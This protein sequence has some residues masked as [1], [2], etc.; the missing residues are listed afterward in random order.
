MKI[1]RKN[2]YFFHKNISYEDYP[3]KRLSNR[4]I[5]NF[6]NENVVLK[7]GWLYYN[8]FLIPTY[9]HYDYARCVNSHVCVQTGIKKCTTINF[10]NS[11]S[12]FQFIHDLEY[13][14][15]NFKMMILYK[16]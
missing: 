2:D 5:E 6:I 13:N 8:D 10:L 15:D 9:W 7:D 4:E 12:S 3:F 11:N 14:I 1:K 16:K